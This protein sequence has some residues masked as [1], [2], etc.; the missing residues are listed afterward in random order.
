MATVCLNQPLISA[1]RASLEVV[2]DGNRLSLAEDIRYLVRMLL[3]YHSTRCQAAALCNILNKGRLAPLATFRASCGCN[4]TIAA[5]HSINSTRVVNGLLSS[6]LSIILLARWTLMDM[7]SI[8]LRASSSSL[9]KGLSSE[10]VYG[11]PHVLTGIALS[12]TAN[13]AMTLRSVQEPT[14]RLFQLAY[15]YLSG[16]RI[17]TAY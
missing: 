5:N 16:C 17:S 7:V 10:P 13:L 9:V 15:S 12:C 1:C 4:A 11:V 6:M 8:Q 2:P 3:K 14:V